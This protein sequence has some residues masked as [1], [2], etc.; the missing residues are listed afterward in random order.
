MKK[1]IRSV[2]ALLCAALLFSAGCTRPG[3]DETEKETTHSTG[4]SP[5]TEEIPDPEPVP[6]FSADGGFYAEGFSLSLTP[7]ANAAGGAYITYT[8][9]GSEPGADSARY[10]S[11][12]DINGTVSVRACLF[13]PDGERLG[14]IVTNTYITE[15][16]TGLYTVAL[17]VDPDDLYS[18]DRGIMANRSGTGA[19]WE[20]PAS[21]EIYGNDGAVLIRQDAGIRLAGSG[22]RSFDPASFRLIARK[23][24]KF[25]ETGLKY[26]GAG[27]FSAELF[28]DGFTSFDRLLLRNGGND[29]PYQARENF[30]RM[31][32]LRD[33]ISN[34]Y[35]AGFS[36]R[37]GVSVFAQRCRPVR[38]YLNGR[39]Y[40]MS[41]LKEDFD[42]RL[43]SERFG[44]DRDKITVI[45]GK[46]LYYQIE[47]GADSELDEWLSLCE[48]AIKNGTSK[49]TEEAYGYVASR[50]DTDNA[51]AYLSVM[52]YLCNTDWPQN[53]AMIWRYTG[54]PGDGEYSD[55][56][57]RFVIRDMD[58]CFALHDAPSRVSNT[59]YT[60]AD[61]DTFY[62][63]L[64]FYRDGKGYSYDK[65]LGFYGDDMKIQG[66]FDFLLHSD[67]FREK[68][69]RFSAI[70]SS[71][72][73][74][75]HMTEVVG[76][77]RGAASSEMKRH[78][79]TWQAAG[80]IYRGYTYGKWTESF[81]G[82]AEF[83]A[84]RPDHYNR[85]MADALSYYE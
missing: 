34:E 16:R 8:T 43:V 53:N 63:L 14:R 22:S 77:L 27:K 65:S 39:Y 2:S 18:G 79:D 23:P 75:D 4:A 70:I 24:D 74:A 11:E 81:D 25:D 45:K 35:C 1:L 67:E 31:D 62:R 80:K 5:L 82:I 85:Y 59:T 19:E 78:I 83:I 9:D 52:L 32:L 60:M 72:D 55:G 44:L 49:D 7:P 21:V 30:L 13:S 73:E 51:A 38:V 15:E 61:T 6:G 10:S 33:C 68:F 54:K 46:K 41:I 36:G 29:S 50:I 40:G 48:Y 57:W 66:L 47:S 37:A 71:A 42:E 28:D 12:I 76:A 26:G 17:T 84:D 56:K 64:V 69:K 58:L 3:T 20:R